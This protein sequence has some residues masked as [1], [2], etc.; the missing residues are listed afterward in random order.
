MKYKL[1][2]IMLCFGFLSSLL[3][4]EIRIYNKANSLSDTVLFGKCIVG[5]YL[6]SVFV[7]E[8]NSDMD[9]KIADVYPSY[10][11]GTPDNV[12]NNEFQEFS[13]ITPSFQNSL[14]PKNS[15]RE[16]TIRYDAK[17]E[18]LI[19][20]IG[21]KIAALKIGL[22]DARLSVPPSDL[23]EL[24]KFRA[25]II[26]AT[27]T[28][29]DVDFTNNQFTLDTVCIN[30]SIPIE[31]N[32]N[33]QNMTTNSQIIVDERFAY[34]NSNCFEFEIQRSDTDPTNLLKNYREQIKRSFTYYPV[35]RDWDTAIYTVRYKP[36]NGTN[37]TDSTS[38]RFV[39][40]GAEQRLKIVDAISGR[41][42][43]DTIDF[44]DVRI[45]NIQSVKI[46]V[47]NLGNL[48]F[49]AFSQ[50]IL[51]EQL[52]H[53]END[54]Q[55]RRNIFESGKHLKIDAVDTFE[56]FFSPS[57]R[58]T[59]I[60]RLV[61]KSDIVNRKILNVNNSSREIVFY[62]KGRGVAP[63]IEVNASEID[64]GS[65]IISEQCPITKDT[66]ITIYNSGN[67]MLRISDIRIEPAVGVPFEFVNTEVTI[68]PAQAYKLPIRFNSQWAE[69]GKIY[70]AE[71]IFDNNSLPEKQNLRIKLKSKTEYLKQCEVSIPKQIKSKSG[72]E[73]RI[74]II[75]EK[76][77]ISTALTA[78]FTI[79]YDKSMLVYKNYFKNN[80]A[81]EAAWDI[82]V[83]NAAA[84][85][86]NIKIYQ[87][88]NY[89]VNRDTLLILAFDT[90][91]SESTFTPIVIEEIKIGNQNCDQIFSYDLAF[92]SGGFEIDSTCGINYKTLKSNRVK[93]SFNSV[94][95]N[96]AS[97]ITN[98]EFNVPNSDKIVIEILNQLGEVVDVPLN[99]ILDKGTYR[100]DYNLANLQ[101]GNYLC[102]IKSGKSIG[103]TKL[104]VVR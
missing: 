19:Y 45:G 30:P 18:L 53:I 85:S 73:I 29:L 78:D 75:V 44:G 57:R 24:E 80:T 70:D 33:L 86:L 10:Y 96:P 100:L 35:N 82:R 43:K 4:A 37:I 93:L 51:S 54:Y 64:F 23:N 89:F 69:P 48:S 62:L 68:L 6:E 83:D 42:N 49:G 102:R 28:N 17:S 84:N 26:S 55:M 61:L 56:I 8:N 34:L 77:K 67:Q 99:K 46:L 58:N 50:E 103:V 11:L 32:T 13:L 94:F 79:S 59:I 66:S 65:I 92:A 101:N 3:R 15:R 87:T 25:F 7:I 95:P 98:I 38:V 14:I 36:N 1:L 2:V 20:P 81:S 39:A 90:F 52:N 5:D 60:G 12:S 74:P 41:V 21:R 104:S 47:K 88:S 31:I 76:N 91:L 72:R 9:L 22:F 63:E 16:F 71:V 40:Y 27:K 97:D